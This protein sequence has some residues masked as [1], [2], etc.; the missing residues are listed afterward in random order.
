MRKKVLGGTALY[1]ES[2]SVR[3]GIAYTVIVRLRIV[4]SSACSGVFWI[5]KKG[6][7]DGAIFG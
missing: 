7:V 4:H 6:E 3:L 5:L 1:L 2:N